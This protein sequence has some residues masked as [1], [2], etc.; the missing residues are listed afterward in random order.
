MNKWLK[1]LGFLILLLLAGCTGMYWVMDRPLPNGT[2][3][4]DADALAEKMLAQL[5]VEEWKQTAWV[6]WNFANRHKFVWDKSRNWAEVRW[7][8][9]CVY[10]NLKELSK[11]KVLVNG[12]EIGADDSQRLIEL[13]L[14]YFNNDSFWLVAPYKVFDEGT[15]RSLVSEEDGS[16][17]L[18]VRYS[19]GGSTPGDSYLWKLNEQGIPQSC[20]MWV[21][22]IP[23]GGVEASWDDWSS[24]P[25]GALIATRHQ[26]GGLL[27]IPIVDLMGGQSFVDLGLSADP[28]AGLEL[29]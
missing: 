29:E 19:S 16:N 20:R 11:S 21:S 18:L 12:S 28:F 25:T 23:I 8:K 6:Q 13:A 17:S 2:V 10:L 14:G 24:L 27:D 7:E 22:I 9:N 3:G 5:H 1:R 15:Q 4:A 26:L